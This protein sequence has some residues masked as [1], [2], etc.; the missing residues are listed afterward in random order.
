VYSPPSYGHFTFDKCAQRNGETNGQ[1]DGECGFAFEK[2]IEL[3]V[4]AKLYRGF[5]L[6]ETDTSKGFRL[7]IAGDLCA[8]DTVAF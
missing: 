1:V 4:E 2:D 7:M 3:V 6:V 5:N 8:Q